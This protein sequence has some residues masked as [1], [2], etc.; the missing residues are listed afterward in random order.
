MKNVWLSLGLGLLL[1]ACSS[2]KPKVVDNKSTIE[3]DY[4][5]TDA[6]SRYRP[7]WIEDAQYW[8]KENKEDIK[9]WNFFSFET[10]ARAD[11]E[12]ACDMAKAQVK[13]DI[14]SGIK[15]KI[16]KTLDSYR[17]DSSTALNEGGFVRSYIDR[18]LKSKISQNLVGTQIVKTYW[19]KRNFKKDLGAARDY[20]GYTCAILSKIQKKNLEIAVNKAFS[21]LYQQS[22][23]L[24][25][26]KPELEKALKEA[27]AE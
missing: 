9:N 7:T 22:K 17:E 12:L 2:Y 10:G 20:V 3:K 6:S 27:L 19:E 25:T 8:S 23:K 4:K 15:T 14:A 26:A 21:D 13:A 18:S 1:M 16:D 24:K 11:R 5:V